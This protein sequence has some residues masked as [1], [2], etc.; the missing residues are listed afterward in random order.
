[1]NLISPVQVWL[2]L[3][4]GIRGHLVK[5]IRDRE[6]NII[7][8]PP[9]RSGPDLIVRPNQTSPLS[10]VSVN[11]PSIICDGDQY[12]TDLIFADCKDAITGIKR[13]RQ[14]LR[15]GERTADE[16]TWDV[17]LPFRQIGSEDAADGTPLL[18][19]LG[20]LTLHQFEGFVQSNWN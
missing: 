4:L 5:V 7:A 18:T 14:Q 9:S 1:M 6:L 17:G 16:W 8:S 13:S 3:L 11:N 2:F 15:F 20:H 19:L 12:G 10:D